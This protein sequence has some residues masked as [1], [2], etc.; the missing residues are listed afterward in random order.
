MTL[1][2]QVCK[3]LLFSAVLSPMFNRLACAEKVASPEIAA[4]EKTK[5]EGTITSRDGDLITIRE[6]KSGKLVRIDLVER[7]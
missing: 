6:K 4:G 3:V 7:H 2:T 1:R 5:V